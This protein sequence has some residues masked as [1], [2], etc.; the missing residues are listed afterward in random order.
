MRY[1]LNEVVYMC[2]PNVG[3]DHRLRVCTMTLVGTDHRLRAQT[4][5]LIGMNHRRR[6]CTVK[7]QRI[8]H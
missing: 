7:V 4:M 8:E 5:T 3:M 2:I 6:V 1:G